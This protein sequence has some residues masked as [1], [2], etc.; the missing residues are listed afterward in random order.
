MAEPFNNQ[1]TKTNDTETFREILRTEHVHRRT[2]NVGQ[3]VDYNAE[4]KTITL[5]LGIMMDLNGSIEPIAPIPDVP[6]IF[7]MVGNR[8]ISFPLE[9]G[10]KGAVIFADRAI[11]RWLELGGVVHP[12]DTRIKHLADAM[13][14]PGI[15]TDCADGFNG[16]QIS[17]GNNQNINLGSNCFDVNSNGCSLMEQL[18]IIANSLPVPNP[19]LVANLQKI[20]GNC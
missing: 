13:F 18:I 7:P 20:R 17:N 6:V 19:V 5:Q 16:V 15:N 9:E 10:D 12:D 4:C 1:T 8:G 11:G 14:I 3:V 2:N